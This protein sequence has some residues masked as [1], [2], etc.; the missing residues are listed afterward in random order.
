MIEYVADHNEVVSEYKDEIFE[1]MRDLQDEMLPDHNY[2][3]T[4]QRD[5]HLNWQMR[6][7]LIL[8]LVEV[9]SRFRL[10]EETLFLAINYIDR[11]LSLKEVFSNRLQLVTIVALSIAIKYE[12]RQGISMKSLQKLCGDS[13]AAEDFFEVEI[14]MLARLRYRLGWPGPL[15][16]LRRI[17]E[18]DEMEPRAG[19][20]AKYLLEAVLPDKSFVAERPSMTAAAAY[21]LARCMLAI[22]EWTPLHVRI[23]EYNYSQLY[24]LMVAILDWLNQPQ[25]SYLA[26][27]NKYCLWENLRVALFVKKKL[28]SG[29]VIEDNTRART[30]LRSRCQK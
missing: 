13:Y 15:I 9:H 26:V 14:Y 18:I 2:M 7:R 17:N 10:R 12:D 11:F 27:F 20:M 24:P 21:C 6:S 28:E 8:W 3:S 19:I 5:T 25:E 23:S 16:F 1:Y 22:G 4:K 29:F 30:F